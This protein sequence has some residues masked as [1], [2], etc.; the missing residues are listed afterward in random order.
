MLP[1]ILVDA[2]RADVVEGKCVEEFDVT[3]A[4]NINEAGVEDY[5]HRI[6]TARAR[7]PRRCKKVAKLI[8]QYMFPEYKV[9]KCIR[10]HETTN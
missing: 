1:A 4:L 8:A 9:T 10:R 7:S 5:Q 2:L 6:V 3:M